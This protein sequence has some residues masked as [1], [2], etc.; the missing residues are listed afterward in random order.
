MRPASF[1]PHF[2]LKSIGQRSI[3]FWVKHYKKLFFLAFL[4]LV[5]LLVL[6][7][8]YY[9]IRYH[10]SAEERQAFIRRTVEET[11]FQEDK[12]RATLKKRDALDAAHKETLHLERELFVPK[13]DEEHPS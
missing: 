10:W 13:P 5:G 4:V 8:Q 2:S 1:I 3:Y 9:L 12:F 11:Q 6:A 7:W